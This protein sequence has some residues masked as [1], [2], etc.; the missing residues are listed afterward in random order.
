M[1]NNFN[2]RME[3][4]DPREID[5]RYLGHMALAYCVFGGELYGVRFTAE[6]TI[7][8][9]YQIKK[10]FGLIEEFGEEKELKLSKRKKCTNLKET[11][12]MKN[13]ETGEI[14]KEFKNIPELCE[15][16]N[17]DKKEIYTILRRKII[18]DGCFFTRV[19][20]EVYKPK[21]DGISNCKIFRLIDP[22]TNEEVMRDKASNIGKKIKLTTAAIYK[23]SKTGSISKN[24]WKVQEVC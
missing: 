1:A 24:G 5:K 10:A 20:D 9:E 17:K 8:K 18:I 4:T 7:G 11:I 23:L 14:V 2:E 13:V 21:A 15:Y 3:Y 16:L 12:K 6:D 19:A 22:K